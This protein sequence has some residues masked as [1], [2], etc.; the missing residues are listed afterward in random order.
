MRD[1]FVRLLSSGAQGPPDEDELIELVTVRYHE[2]PLVLA[3]LRNGGVAAVGVD[4]YNPATRTVADARIM[5]RR[6][7]AVD[8]QRILDDRFSHEIE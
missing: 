6:G 3:E 7:D 2:G 5:V 4:T 1:R 8:A